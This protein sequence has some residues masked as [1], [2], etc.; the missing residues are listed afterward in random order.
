M[1]EFESAVVSLPPDLSSVVEARK[2]VSLICAAVGID[3]SEPELVVQELTAN[4]VQHAGHRGGFE[5]SI[6]RHGD[7]LWIRVRDG[8]PCRLPDSSPG[9]QLSERGRGLAIVKALSAC[10]D[11]RISPHGKTVAVAFKLPPSPASDHSHI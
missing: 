9:D 11:Y 10:F 4:A 7:L 1:A 2:R 3:G 6:A 5:M 8:F